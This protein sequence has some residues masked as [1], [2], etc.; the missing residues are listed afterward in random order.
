MRH[1]SEM[2]GFPSRFLFEGGT[3]DIERRGHLGFL[4][5]QVVVWSVLFTAFGALALSFGV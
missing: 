2:A 5:G 4:F 3:M 1:V